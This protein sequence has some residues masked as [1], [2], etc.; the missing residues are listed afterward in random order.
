MPRYRFWI[1][2]LLPI[3]SNPPHTTFQTT[4]AASPQ[5][6][7]PTVGFTPPGGLPFAPTARRYAGLKK[8]GPRFLGGA[9]LYGQELRQALEAKAWATVA[10]LTAPSA[11]GSAGSPVA[12]LPVVMG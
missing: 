4:R 7:P 6:P 1:S 11:K 8:L 10:G 3:S 5:L 12:D 2:N 9:A